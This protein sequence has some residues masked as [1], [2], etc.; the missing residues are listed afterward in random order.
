MGKSRLANNMAAAGGGPRPSVTRIDSNKQ[1][2]AGDPG[3]ARPTEEFKEITP[4]RSTAEQSAARL[5][6]KSKKIAKGDLNSPVN[7]PLPR[8]KKDEDED[9]LPP[10]SDSE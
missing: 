8:N 3:F 10:D 9:D 6:K 4:E 7:P 1:T 5:N 2:L